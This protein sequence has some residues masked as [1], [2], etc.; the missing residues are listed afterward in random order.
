MVVEA[1]KSDFL[2]A[3][4]HHMSRHYFAILGVGEKLI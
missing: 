1:A 3:K 2:S 4:R